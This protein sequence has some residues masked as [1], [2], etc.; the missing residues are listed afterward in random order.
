MQ[1]K[2]IRIIGSM[3]E[4]SEQFSAFCQYFFHQSLPS[5]SPQEI[6]LPHSTDQDMRL[7]KLR[8]FV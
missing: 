1:S 7:E 3:L 8:E 6:L 2:I 5:K 4:G